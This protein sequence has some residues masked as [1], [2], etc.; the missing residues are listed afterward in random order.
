MSIY[1]P[2]KQCRIFKK[3]VLVGWAAKLRL[4]AVNWN[5]TAHSV[6]EDW[7]MLFVRLDK[8]EWQFQNVYI[9]ETGASVVCKK[10]HIKTQLAHK[11]KHLSHILGFAALPQIHVQTKGAKFTGE[12]NR[13]SIKICFNDKKHWTNKETMYQAHI[14]LL[15]VLCSTMRA[16]TWWKQ[17]CLC[18]LQEAVQVLMVRKLFDEVL[19]LKTSLLLS[20]TRVRFRLTLIAAIG[21]ASPAVSPQSIGRIIMRTVFM[22]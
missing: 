4:W 20:V 1:F 21:P 10:N 3:Q 6:I 13:L 5:Q 16:F 18:L 15:C 9:W 14:F 22:E 17:Q 11:L 2:F 8:T 12:I 19:W 7:S